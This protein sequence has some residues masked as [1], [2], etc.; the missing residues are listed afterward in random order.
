MSKASSEMKV[1]LPAGL[2]RTLFSSWVWRMAWRDSRS[3]RIRLV[4][5]AVAIVAGITALVA[6]HSL[7]ASLERGIQSQTKELLGSDLR[8]SARDPFGEETVEILSQMAVKVSY[9]TAFPS[10]VKFANGEARLLQIRSFTG[11]YPFYGRLESNPVDAVDLLKGTGGILLESSVLEQFQT[12]VGDE[13]EFGGKALPIIGEVVKGAPKASRFTGFAPEAYVSQRVVEESNLLG[14]N[15]L[16]SY[17]L[18]LKV[19][20]SLSGEALKTKVLDS[21]PEELS[22]TWRLETP[23]DR[24]ETLERAL[25]MLQKFLSL[26]A[27]ASLVLGAIG[28]AGAIHAHISRRT[29]TVA[30]LR[31]MGAPAQLAA[32]IYF[33]QAISLGVLGAFGG[34]CLGVGVQILTL[35]G[36]G[37]LLPVYVEKTVEW[38]VVARTTF[39]GFGICCAFALIPLWRVRWISPASA[40]RDQAD[41]GVKWRRRWLLQYPLIGILFGGLVYLNEPDWMTSVVIL[42]VLLLAFGVLGGLAKIL[43]WLARRLLRLNWP[44]VMRQG[45]ANLYRPGNQTLLFMLSLGLGTFIIVTILLVGKL[46]QEAI[47]QVDSESAPNLYLVD[48]Q[49]EQ[50][51]EVQT[52]LADSGLSAMEDAPMISMR[53]T[54]VNGTPVRELKD[55]PR[56]INRREFRSTYRSQLSQSERLVGGKWHQSVP[57][58]FA[59]RVAVA[60]GRLVT[61][62]SLERDIADDLNVKLGDT[63]TLDVQGMPIV[64]VVTSLR[65]VDW[66]QMNLNFFMV[67]PP[68]ILD[69]A[70]AFH[71]ITTRAP[72]AV[73]SGQ[74]QA[75]LATALPN[76]SAID[77]TPILNELR[78]ITQTMSLVISILASFTVLAGLPIFLGTMLNGRD[79]RLEECRLFR[80]LGASTRQIRSILT[81]E[82]LALGSLAAA[83]GLVLAAIANVAISLYVFDLRSVSYL[84]DITIAGTAFLV[85][86]GLSV[87]TGRLLDQ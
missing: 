49:P 29:R 75:K 69:Q 58:D 10:M 36:F 33:A 86:L 4:V 2:V 59:S 82:Y 47:G 31:C 52:V 16:A 26:I 68:G 41:S 38:K 20:G 7:K 32:A 64:A 57:V 53:L 30:I 46:T 25:E 71:V 50:V 28:V 13:V 17:S 24:S 21:F 37:D 5:F 14:S 63:L 11:E 61:P 18:H 84:P 39:T 73:S 40:L 48:V 70:P 77:L 54:E 83:T 85:V 6:T 66:G 8:I 12:Q 72:D 79:T 87:I 76:V 62:L 22:Q 55:I 67:F 80:I 15:S 74:F 3:Q 43:V 9:E 34:A 65:E 56:W 1:G 44:Y 78:A 81:T 45:V 35:M 51:D 19:G 60:E 23:D 42:M 27:L